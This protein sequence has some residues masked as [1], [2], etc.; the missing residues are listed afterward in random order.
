VV[1]DESA[2]DPSEELDRQKIIQAIRSSLST[3]TE[4]EE[5]IIRLRFGISEEVNDHD[6]FPMGRHE[7]EEIQHLHSLEVQNEHA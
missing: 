6:S 4:R 7:L 3:L 1:P 5:K 2:A